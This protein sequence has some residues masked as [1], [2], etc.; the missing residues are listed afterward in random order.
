MVTDAEIQAII[1]AGEPGIGVLLE[2]YEVAERSYSS[3]AKPMTYVVVAGSN[4]AS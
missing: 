3:V 2:T 4:T 1:D